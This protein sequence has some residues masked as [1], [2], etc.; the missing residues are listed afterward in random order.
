MLMEQVGLLLNLVDPKLKKFFLLT[1]VVEMAVME[2]EEEMGVRVAKEEMV[3]VVVL[4]IKVKVQALVEVGME[5]QEVM[6]VMA[7]MVDRE[8]QV[9]EEEME[10]MQEMEAY[11]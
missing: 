1:V 6:E 5:D 10:A 4:D 9:E 7:E 3:E 11:V 2:D 8:D